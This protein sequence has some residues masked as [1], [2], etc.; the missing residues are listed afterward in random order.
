MLAPEI[1]MFNVRSHRIMAII[2]NNNNNNNGNNNNDNNN[3]N[4]NYSS[5][6]SPKNPT[7]TTRINV[8]EQIAD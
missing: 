1:I 2:I 7:A 4:Q 5:H 8:F 6:P 3:N